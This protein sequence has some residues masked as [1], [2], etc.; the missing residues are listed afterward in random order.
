QEH[1]DRIGLLAGR[2]AG[3][4]DSDAPRVSDLVDDLRNDI[5]RQRL[6]RVGIPEEVRDVD[7][8]RVEQRDVL[9]GIRVEKVG[10][11]REGVDVHLRHAGADAPRERG[12]LVLAEIEV[13]ACAQLFQQGAEIADE[14]LGNLFEGIFGAVT[15]ASSPSAGTTRV[16]SAGPMS[17]SG[18]VK[19]TQLVARAAVG[20]P[21]WAAVLGSCTSVVPPLALMARIPSAPSN[22]DPERITPMARSP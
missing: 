13:V 22:P 1:C 21:V 4:P 20:M 3:A 6:P 8:D 11:G 12:F 14:L 7:E 9:V 18:S 2:A 19:S 17:S 16:A 15:H 5:V 10:V